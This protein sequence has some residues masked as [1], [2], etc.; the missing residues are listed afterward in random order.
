MSV[1]NRADQYAARAERADSTEAL[2]EEAMQEGCRLGLEA[3]AKICR[4]QAEQFVHDAHSL[5]A[6]RARRGRHEVGVRI[7]LGEAISKL[8]PSDVIEGK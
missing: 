6:S 5:N 1:S 3:A 7:R 4:D 2:F 8:Q